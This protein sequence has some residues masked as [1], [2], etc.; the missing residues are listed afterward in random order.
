MKSQWCIRRFSSS[1]LLRRLYLV[2]GWVVAGGAG[3]GGGGVRR[4]KL[5]PPGEPGSELGGVGGGAY[6][7]LGRWVGW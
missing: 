2:V 6:N 1:G 5:V 3:Y 4:G 7:N